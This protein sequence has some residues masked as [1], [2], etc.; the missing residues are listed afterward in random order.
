MMDSKLSN[1]PIKSEA[2]A[3]FWMNMN[4]RNAAITALSIHYSYMK[5]YMY[6]LIILCIYRPV[7]GSSATVGDRYIYN[8]DNYQRVK[9]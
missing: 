3:A 1:F 5:S 8:H 2:I 7:P 9:R 4:T 6:N